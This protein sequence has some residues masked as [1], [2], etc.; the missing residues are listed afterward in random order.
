MR[1]I[2]ADI[3]S[4]CETHLSGQNII[5]IDSYTWIGY[6]RRDIHRD[7]PKSSGG[8]GILIKQWV[9]DT[10][11]ISVI[12]K[13][14]DGIIGV[15]FVHKETDSDFVVFSCYLPP[16]NSTRGKLLWITFVY[17]MTRLT[18]ISISRLL[19]FSRLWMRMLY[20][21]Y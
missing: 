3:Y 14:V 4:I 20:T 16:E 19:R 2:D 13:T 10:Y 1:G 21:D 12:D 11:N 9:C 8:V 6:N 17:R 15:K 5:E 7:A 18:N